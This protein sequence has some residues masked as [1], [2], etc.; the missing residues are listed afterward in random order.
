MITADANCTV[1]NVD[2]NGAR[3]I[4]ILFTIIIPDAAKEYSTIP[5]TTVAMVGSLLACGL[6]TLFALFALFACSPVLLL[7]LL[8]A[9]LPLLLAGKAS[10]VE[11]GKEV[12]IFAGVGVWLAL[13]TDTDRPR[14]AHTPRAAS[15]RRAGGQRCFTSGWS[16]NLSAYT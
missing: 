7:L 4:T 13:R 9:V 3:C 11:T 2:G 10:G 12:R 16:C 5:K 15:A 1:L 6:G 8:L 14:A